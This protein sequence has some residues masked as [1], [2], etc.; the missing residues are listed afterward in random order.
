MREQLRA[1]E[2]RALCP[3]TRVRAKRCHLL[4]QHCL[5]LDTTRRR[6]AREAQE[7][8]QACAR[9]GQVR[10]WGSLLPVALLNV[11]SPIESPLK[12]C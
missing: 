3:L 10:P 2:D 7:G 12:P 9:C 11:R 8:G 1:A 4:A 6:A 5:L